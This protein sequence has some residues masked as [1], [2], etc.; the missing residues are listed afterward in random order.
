[1]P[2]ANVAQRAR[3]SVSFLARRVLR[4]AFKASSIAVATPI[5]LADLHEA[6]VRLAAR[7]VCIDFPANVDNREI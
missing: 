3:L 2:E 5:E 7:M 6:N 1:M 4:D